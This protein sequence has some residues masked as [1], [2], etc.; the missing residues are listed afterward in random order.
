MAKKLVGTKDGKNVAVMAAYLGDEIYQGPARAGA[1]ICEWPS[2]GYRASWATTLGGSPT[3]LFEDNTK[4][5]SG[6]HASSRPEDVPGILVSNRPLSIRDPGL[7]DLSATA[8]KLT[9]QK[10]PEGSI[11]RPLF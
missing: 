10:P 2:E 1:P 3:A 8:Y 6:D 11:G 9:G 5:W 7:E 4:P